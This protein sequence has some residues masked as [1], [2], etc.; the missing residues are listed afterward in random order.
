MWQEGEFFGSKE[1]IF[2]FSRNCM[3]PSKRDR[4]FSAAE[5]LSLPCGDFKTLSRVIPRSGKFKS[6]YSK[7]AVQSNIQKKKSFTVNLEN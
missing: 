3:T 1:F 2:T 5:H 4:V 6:G 7:R